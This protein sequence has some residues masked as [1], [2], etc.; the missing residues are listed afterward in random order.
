MITYNNTL[1]EY[2]KANDTQFKK[3]VNEEFEKNKIS[4]F[5][6]FVN[7][8]I[9]YNIGLTSCSIKP[10]IP[11]QWEVIYLIDKNNVFSEEPGTFIV[12]EEPLNRKEAEEKLS[13]EVIKLLSVV[14][15][16]EVNNRIKL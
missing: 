7:E 14:D 2:F 12:N 6:Q 15:M 4:S 3:F 5:I 13:V 10:L 1:I 9:F 11:D 8:V 16:S